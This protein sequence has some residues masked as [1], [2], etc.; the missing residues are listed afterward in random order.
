MKKYSLVSET[1]HKKTFMDSKE[2]S[3]FLE[4]HLSRNTTYTLHIENVHTKK[5]A[6]YQILKK[7]DQVEKLV[8]DLNKLRRNSKS[9]SLNE[10]WL[11]INNAITL[12]IHY[13]TKELFNLKPIEE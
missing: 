1:G 2:L 13:A 8:A 12:N 10:N 11:T 3:D 6:Y 9:K 7:L 4:N 5:E